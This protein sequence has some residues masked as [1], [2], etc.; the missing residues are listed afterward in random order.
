MPCSPDSPSATGCLSFLACP[1]LEV[2]MMTVFDGF[3]RFF[4]KFLLF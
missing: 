2:V 1:S 3:L 4:D